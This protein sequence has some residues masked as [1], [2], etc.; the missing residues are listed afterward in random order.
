MEALALFCAIS[1]IA[2]PTPSQRAGGAGEESRCEAWRAVAW[3]GRE[4]T[5]RVEARPDSL[6]EEGRHV[7]P[8]ADAW[9]VGSR[10]EARADSRA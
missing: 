2:P 7:E 5:W 9:E 1:P 6:E 4:E 8:R 3:R 10:I